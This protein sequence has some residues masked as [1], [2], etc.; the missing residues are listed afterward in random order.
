V[1]WG[2]SIATQRAKECKNPSSD[3]LVM[4]EAKISRSQFLQVT[5]VRKRTDV[6]RTDVW[7]VRKSVISVLLGGS[8]RPVKVGCPVLRKGPDA[9]KVPIVRWVGV[10]AGFE[11]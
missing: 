3:E 10:N 7:K 9:C 2:M 6:W 5:D 1:V 4:A 11:I 8:G